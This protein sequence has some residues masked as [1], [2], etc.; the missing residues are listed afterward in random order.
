[1]PKEMMMPLYDE[2]RYLTKLYM[3]KHKLSQSEMG[4]R[5]GASQK[6]ISNWAFVSPVRTRVLR[7]KQLNALVALLREERLA[8]RQIG[9]GTAARLLDRLL[10]CEV[11]HDVGRPIEA[12]QALRDLK[13]IV[14]N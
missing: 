14:E 9:T 3:A 1:M 2:L 8:S 7:E 6:S 11:E 12:F 4:D 5:I 13:A 10:D